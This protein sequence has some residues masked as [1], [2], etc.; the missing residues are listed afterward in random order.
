MSVQRWWITEHE[1]YEN[2]AGEWVKFAD[3]EK[4]AKHAYEQGREHGYQHGYDEGRTLGYREGYND[5][6]RSRAY[7]EQVYGPYTQHGKGENP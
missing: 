5:H 2:P 7:A 4:W 6:A 1:Q 3:H